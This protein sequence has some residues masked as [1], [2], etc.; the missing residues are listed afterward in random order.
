MPGFTSA[1]ALVRCCIVPSSPLL[2][3]PAHCTPGLEP[4]PPT[5]QHPA[6]Y[7]WDLR[8]QRCLQR[9]QDE[10]CLQGTSMAC[11]PDG[12]LFASGGCPASSQREGQ[13]VASAA[14]LVGA[15]L[16]REVFVLILVACASLR[17][18]CSPA[19]MCRW[20]NST[21]VGHEHLPKPLHSAGSNSGVVNIYS[22][23][24]QQEQQQHTLFDGGDGSDWVLPEA[25][26]AGE[27]G[28]GSHAGLPAHCLQPC[29]LFWCFGQHCLLCLP[30]SGHWSAVSSSAWRRQAAEDG[31][32][33]EHRH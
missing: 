5:P 22:R 32:Q 7:V 17:V 11:S 30:S 8:T 26:T 18:P 4:L 31:A 21:W 12:A 15:A 24:Q 29:P 20:R 23:E 13:R 3:L 28:P 9:H 14:L 33:P 27:H 19:S 2:L 1:C 16:T 10:G 25:P 6:V